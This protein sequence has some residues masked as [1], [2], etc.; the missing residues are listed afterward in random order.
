MKTSVLSLFFVGAVALA[1]CSCSAGF[2]EDNC[3]RTGSEAP[4]A[5]S[6]GVNPPVEFDGKSKGE[7]FSLR[8]GYVSAHKSL[9]KGGYRPSEAVF[10]QIVDGKPWWGL[11]GQFCKGDGQHSIDG[12]S[13]ESRFICNPFLLL[14]VDTLRPWKREGR[15]DPVYLQP[16]SLQWQAAERRA[17]A[18]Y[19]MSDYYDRV[20]RTGFPVASAR[21]ATLYLK[22]L[23]A[24]DFGYEYLCLDTASCSNI[25][26]RDS[27][28]MFKDCVQLLGFIHCG[29]SC[30]YPGGCNNGSPLEPDLHFSIGRLPAVMR[31]K[32]WKSMPADTRSEPDFTFIIEFK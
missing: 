9:L 1:L 12:A 23:N 29:G 11:E 4:A 7:I 19:D 8:A 21:S 18:V 30:G 3:L 13:E 20:S 26:R 6:I 2:L 5:K 32:L 25:G 24:R 28:G 10:G 31:C 27:A 15:C 17:L 16:V 14:A 22:N